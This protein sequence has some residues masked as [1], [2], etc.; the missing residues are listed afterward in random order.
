MDYLSSLFLQYTWLET[1]DEEVV[2][3]IS[4]EL[5]NSLTSEEKTTIMDS[6]AKESSGNGNEVGWCIIILIFSKTLCLHAS[7]NSTLKMI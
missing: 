6:M 2:Q 7:C 5:W 3:K 4:E 1:L